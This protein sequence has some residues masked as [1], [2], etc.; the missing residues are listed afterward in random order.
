M[1]NILE[2]THEAVKYYAKNMTKGK[3][4]L[5]PQLR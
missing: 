5:K 3:V 4:I 1:E 2:N